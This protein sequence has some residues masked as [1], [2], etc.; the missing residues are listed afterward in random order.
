[1]PHVRV[2]ARQS[3]ANK[4]VKLRRR[5]KYSF[6]KTC[7]S[8]RLGRHPGYSGV[9]RNSEKNARRNP[10]PSPKSAKPQNGGPDMDAAFTSADALSQFNREDG[11]IGFAASATSYTEAASSS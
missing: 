11:Y 5:G 3:V 9:P 1:V 2:C 6:G 4:A 10:Q 8:E 7:R